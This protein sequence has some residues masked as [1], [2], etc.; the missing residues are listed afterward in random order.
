MGSGTALVLLLPGLGDALA[1]GPILRGLRRDHWTL[2]ALTMHPPVS[3]YLRDV[4]V[5]REI[6]EMP[7][8]PGASDALRATA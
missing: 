7:I 2:D 8:R 3:E 4:G 6:V 1:A 5:V